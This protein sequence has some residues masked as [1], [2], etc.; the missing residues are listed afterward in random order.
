MELKKEYPDHSFA[1]FSPYTDENNWKMV[2]EKI[3]ESPIIGFAL[4]FYAKLRDNLGLSS[5]KLL[6]GENIWKLRTVSIEARMDALWQTF[7]E[8]E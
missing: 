4:R 8:E 5:V 7:K 2:E 3:G 6:S 1:A